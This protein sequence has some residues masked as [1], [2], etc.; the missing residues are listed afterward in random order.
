MLDKVTRVRVTVTWN[1]G[2]KEMMD[3]GLKADGSFPH[4]WNKIINDYKNFPTVD[5]VKIE[6]Y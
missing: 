3:F 1:S 6:R 5:D 2:R 4:K